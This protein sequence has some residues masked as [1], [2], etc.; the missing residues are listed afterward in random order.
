MANVNVFTSLPESAD[1]DCHVLH[2]IDDDRVIVQ[3][4][5]K[6][7]PTSVA[8]SVARTSASARDNVTGGDRTA[9][10]VIGDTRVTNKTNV[11]GTG[12][13]VEHGTLCAGTIIDRYELSSHWLRA[14]DRGRHER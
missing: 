10:A 8:R 2:N 3:G 6:S 11:S 4:M 1:A 9:T 14:I 13:R 5:R 7:I 12:R